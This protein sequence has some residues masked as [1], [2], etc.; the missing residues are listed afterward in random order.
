MGEPFILTFTPP[1]L[2][3]LFSSPLRQLAHWDVL[4]EPMHGDY[5]GSRLGPGILSWM[6]NQTAAI[7]PSVVTF[8]N[9]FGIL[10]YPNKQFNPQTYLQVL[11][12]C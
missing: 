5:F 6:F 4:N 7:D 3:P 12:W 2:S 9:D 8:V 1:F 11:E 10:E